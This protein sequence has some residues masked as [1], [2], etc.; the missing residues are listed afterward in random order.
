MDRFKNYGLWL[1]LFSLLG[2]V[3][4]D[5]FNVDLVQSQYELYVNTIMTILILLGIVNNPSIGIGYR[6]RRRK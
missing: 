4:Q 1:S 2:M 3:L 6:D 5:F